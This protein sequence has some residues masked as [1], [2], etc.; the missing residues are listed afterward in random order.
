MTRAILPTR[1]A[2]AKAISRAPATA[3]ADGGGCG[4]TDG[5]LDDEKKN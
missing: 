3:M 4:S 2:D 1:L 5:D